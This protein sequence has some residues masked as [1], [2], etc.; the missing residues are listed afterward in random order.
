MVL[1]VAGVTH[2]GLRH[3]LHVGGGEVQAGDVGVLVLVYA[4]EERPIGAGA[5]RAGVNGPDLYVFAVLPWGGDSGRQGDVR[6]KEQGAEDEQ[7]RAHLAPPRRR[8]ARGR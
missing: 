7:T 1:G 4:D 2:Q 5:G 8:P 6:N 3:R